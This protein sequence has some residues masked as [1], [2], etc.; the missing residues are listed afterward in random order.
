MALHV[1][2]YGHILRTL[3]WD[4]LRASYFNVLWTSVE[5]VL[6]TLVGDV[7]WRYIEDHVGTSIGRLLGMSP[8]RPQDVVLLSGEYILRKCR[9]LLK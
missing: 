5:V 9:L 1:G 8:G 2:E 4:V 7:P 6:R 3:Y